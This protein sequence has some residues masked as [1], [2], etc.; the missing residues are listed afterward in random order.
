MDYKSVMWDWNGT[1]FD[2]LDLCY[3]IYLSLSKLFQLQ[4][5]SL[6]E[7]RRLYRFPLTDFFADLGFCGEHKELASA[8]R[9]IYVEKVHTCRIHPGA[10]AVLKE[11]LK[12]GIPQ[13]VVS[14]HNHEDLL[15]MVDRYNLTRYFSTINGLQSAEGCSK[16]DLAQSVLQREQLSGESVLFIGD[17]SHDFDVAKACNSTSWLIASGHSALERLAQC[18]SAHVFPSLIAVVETVFN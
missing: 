13:H 9:K 12:L 16:I 14:A 7:Y 18:E 17:T 11:F 2:D 1:I 4:H 5:L 3:E 6:Q 8:F 10:R 15:Y